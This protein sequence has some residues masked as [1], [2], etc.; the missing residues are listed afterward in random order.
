MSN[1][2]G[3]IKLFRSIIESEI[4]QLPPLYLRVFER[5]ILEANHQDNEIPYKKNGIVTTKL[6]KRGEKL[7]SIRQ[8]SEWVGWYERG[9]FKKPNPKLIKEIIDY[10]VESEM[11]SIYS[12]SNRTETHYKVIN[13][14]VY[15][16]KQDIKVTEQK[17]K[18]NEVET[19]KK[20]LAP[21][22]KNVNNVK[23]DKNENKYSS[24]KEIFF[25]WNQINAGIKHG[26][27][28]FTKDKDKITIVI[29]KYNI[30]EIKKC[31]QR[32]ANAVNDKS[33]F[34]NTRWNLFDFI[35]QSNGI[36]KWND[37]GQEW[38]RYIDK[39]GLNKK[40]EVK[41]KSKPITRR[42]DW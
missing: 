7:T 19:E 27:D 30:D 39:K 20:R 18:R 10:L 13:Y 34:Y 4:Y 21:Q 37:E 32:L 40:K 28:T 23:N 38:I 1:Q 42:D 29:K 33:Y 8:V 41:E 16:E 5:L 6:I 2:L 25:Y 14:E 9:I 26:E 22:N 35:K 31:I 11:I 17:Q 12:K 36:R 24:E 15:Q 3:Y